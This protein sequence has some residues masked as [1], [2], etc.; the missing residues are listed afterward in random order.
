MSGRICVNLLKLVGQRRDH[1]RPLLV[2]VSEHLF[3]PN[4]LAQNQ[5]QSKPPPP[6]PLTPPNPIL[7]KP[8]PPP[9]PPTSTA[10]PLGS[11]PT[12]SFNK[13]TRPP[14]PSVFKN[15]PLPQVDSNSSFSSV[16]Q[17]SN[18]SSASR[19]PST[20]ANNNSFTSPQKRNPTLSNNLPQQILPPIANNNNKKMSQQNNNPPPPP[21][22]FGRQNVLP[23]TSAQTQLEQASSLANHQDLHPATIAVNN[24]MTKIGGGGAFSDAPQ[25]TPVSDR[26][27][28]VDLPPEF[29]ALFHVSSYFLLFFYFVLD[30]GERGGGAL[31]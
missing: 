25:G 11:T 26:N 14:H 22:A 1:V 2:P 17:T 31:V 10:D 19:R 27:L 30:E 24:V 20:S 6:R 7:N 21:L 29:A 9:S 15:Q 23:S 12:Q 16:Q 3:T 18:S 5:V 28:D 13:Q 8:L 4:S